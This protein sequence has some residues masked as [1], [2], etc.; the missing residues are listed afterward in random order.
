MKKETIITI[1]FTLFAAV[2][3]LLSLHGLPGNPTIKE[4][5][6]TKWKE[7]G[8]LDLSPDRGRYALAYSIIED[9][10][11]QFSLD[12]ALFVTPDLGILKNGQYVSL[13]APG[14]SF[15][16]M[17]GYILGKQFDL[18]QV[19]TFAI[20]ALFAL[21]NFILIKSIAERLGAHPFAALLGALAFVFATPAFPY[22]A[23]LYQHHITVFFI[24]ASAYLL[25]RWNNWWS[26]ALVWFLFAFSVIVDNPNILLMFPIAVYA[27]GRSVV[28]QKHTNGLNVNINV[29]VFLAILAVIVPFSFFLLFNRATY[30]NP[31]QLAGTVDRVKSISAA[32]EPSQLGAE[33]VFQFRENTG[34]EKNAVGFFNTRNLSNGFYTHFLS[35]DRGIIWYA[36]VVLLGILGLTRL[37]RRN[38]YAANLF[39]AIA[40]TNILVYS[41]W[42]DP[43]GGWAFGSRYM[44]PLYAILA[45]GLGFAISEWKKNYIF[46]GIFLLVFGYSVFVNTAGALTTNANPPKV[47]V[48]GLE[49]VTGR[50]EKYTYWRNWD[51]IIKSGTKSFV[52]ETFL[53]NKM[54]AQLYFSLIVGSII[55]GAFALIAGLVLWPNRWRDKKVPV[56]GIIDSE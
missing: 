38:A 50:E 2:I 47:E 13:F 16:V 1:V 3:L 41:M 42:G 12:V 6:S 35:P 19:G 21:F 31:L 56:E 43:Y 40:G 8:P 20:I 25:L 26:L 11:F 23:T 34:K 7:N 53:K 37:Y 24:L 46:A 48:L 22:A 27:L 10:S 5:N 18:A 14:L 45:I 17:P 54:T 51:Y 4:L 49:K 33:M 32:N 44:I 36:P 28:L 29:P 30:G 15:L 39:V 55:S 9:K 52:Y